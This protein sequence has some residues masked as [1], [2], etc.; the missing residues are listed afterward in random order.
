M[1]PPVVPSPSVGSVVVVLSA[2][3]KDWPVAGDVIG[4]VL[5]RDVP[6]VAQAVPQLRLLGGQAVD[7]QFDGVGSQ[8]RGEDF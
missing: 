4:P 6:D 3:G 1:A 7:E 5:L 2:L 8:Q